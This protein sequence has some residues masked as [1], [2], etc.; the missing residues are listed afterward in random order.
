VTFAGPAAW[1][2]IAEQQEAPSLFNMMG[3]WPAVLMLVVLWIF[4]IQRPQRREQAQRQSMLAALK[5]NDHV[6][7]TSGIFGVVTNI[8]PEADEIT[9][10]VDESSN[11]KLRVTRASVARVITDEPSSKN[12]GGSGGE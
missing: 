4:M 5:K 12:D 1:V 3:L 9:I 6:L 8:R 2:L 7:L 10:R 11:T